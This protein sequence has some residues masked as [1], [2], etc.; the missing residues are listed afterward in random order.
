MFMCNICGRNIENISYFHFHI[1]TSIVSEFESIYKC[2]G[3][4]F[5]LECW[6]KV[7]LIIPRPLQ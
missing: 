6:S 4:Y 2:D 7:H 5:M 1:F 3:R